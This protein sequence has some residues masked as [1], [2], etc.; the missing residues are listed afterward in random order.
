MFKD[1]SKIL[2]LYSFGI[3]HQR[4][5]H[6]TKRRYKMHICL[7]Q[8]AKSVRALFQKATNIKFYVGLKVFCSTLI[9]SKINADKLSGCGNAPAERRAL[10]T[11]DLLPFFDLTHSSCRCLTGICSAHYKLHNFQKLQNP[12][13]MQV[14][15]NRK[16]L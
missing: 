6:S 5:L 3:M 11:I 12:E 1:Q 13:G 10:A 9:S 14:K 8:T 16:N 4:E 7:L 15:A 2:C